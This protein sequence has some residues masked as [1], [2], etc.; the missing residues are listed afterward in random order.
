MCSYKH[1][2]QHYVNN[3]TQLFTMSRVFS[4]IVLLSYT[5][6]YYNCQYYVEILTAGFQEAIN[7]LAGSKA[8]M[9]MYVTML[10][11]LNFFNITFMTVTNYQ[12]IPSED[13]YFL[14][15]LHFFLFCNYLISS[16]IF[17]CVFLFYTHDP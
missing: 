9:D 7:I 13:G 14:C 16:V 17:I 12:V 4:T 15:I 5:G 11:I 6:H 10:C 1:Y 8:W 2:S 3:Y